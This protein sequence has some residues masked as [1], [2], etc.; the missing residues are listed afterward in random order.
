MNLENVQIIKKKLKN[1]LNNREII[2]VILFG[3]TVKGKANPKDIDIAIITSKENKFE[4]KGFHIS[5]IKPEEFLSRDPHSLIT[6]LLKEG[7]SLKNEKYFA[8]T[9]RFEVKVM[10]LYRLNKLPNSKKVKIVRLLRGNKKERGMVR[11]YNGAWLSNQVFIIPPS[12]DYI[13]EQ[14][15]INQEVDFEKKHILIH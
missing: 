11:E 7:Y 5:I 9:L 2:D 1:I 13:F 12:S 14:F 4:A 8:E 3:S 10:Y 6:T 15:F